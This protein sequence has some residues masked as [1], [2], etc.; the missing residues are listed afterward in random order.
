[1]GADREIFTQITLA[2]EKRNVI[3]HCILGAWY[4]L[5]FGYECTVQRDVDVRVSPL[6]EGALAS[7]STSSSDDVSGLALHACRAIWLLLLSG[8]SP[9]VVALA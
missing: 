7:T 5:G 4:G 1:M 9:L 3:P 8:W 2:L 6:R